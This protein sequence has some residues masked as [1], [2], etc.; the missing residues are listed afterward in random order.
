MDLAGRS[1]IRR[2][3]QPHGEEQNSETPQLIEPI[4]G[5]T[6]HEEGSSGNMFFIPLIG[7]VLALSITFLIKK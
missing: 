5:N 1:R 3:E 7:V 2:I 6:Q 4:S